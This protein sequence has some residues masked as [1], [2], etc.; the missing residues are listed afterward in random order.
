LAQLVNVCVLF[1]ERNSGYMLPAI[2][3]LERGC[4]NRSWALNRSRASIKS[5]GS[6][7]IVLTEVGGL[8]FKDLRYPSK[9]NYSSNLNYVISAEV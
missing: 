3:L 9:N 4:T 2:S 7:L 5:R 8:L 1:I 6:D